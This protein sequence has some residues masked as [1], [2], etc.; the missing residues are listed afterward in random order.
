MLSAET[1]T[2][3]HPLLVLNMMNR[4]VRAAETAEAVHSH[5]GTSLEDRPHGYASAVTH[6][7]RV[8]AEDL[9]AT[10]IVGLT[11]TGLTA[12]LLSR[13]RAKVPIF[14]FSPDE[15]VC[16]RLALWWGI[17]PVHQV[18]AADL[19][20]NI[21]AMERYLVEHQSAQPA[22]TVV[23]TGAHP[24]EAGAHTNFVKFQVLGRT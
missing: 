19:E 4:I 23:V 7:A 13:T 2:G 3:R 8:L 22:D 21:A 17:S 5:A 24:F 18:L 11:R 12:Q 10:A 9:Q 16:R 20:A 1:A 6:A 15:E 14:A